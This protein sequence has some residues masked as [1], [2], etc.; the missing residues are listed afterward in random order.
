MKGIRKILLP[1]MIII[2]FVTTLFL[3]YNR[4]E[5]NDIDMD[6]DAS[7]PTELHPIV[8]EKKNELLEQAAEIDIDVVITEEIR[9]IDRQNELYE[10]GRS[11]SGNIVTNARG[12]QSYHNYG[13]A[14]DYALRDDNGELIWDIHYDGN[15]NGKSDWFEVADL[16]KELGF[17]WGGDWESF[18]DYPHL[19][20]DFGLRI[21]QLQRGM[22][23]DPDGSQ[24]EAGQ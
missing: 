2:L 17:D 13:L 23:P 22:R 12:G 10:Q 7:L 5:D 24:N 8:E 6:E 19:Q 9:S 16:A 11:T 1:W 15:D 4:I 14:I 21:D 3:L 18:K 20:M